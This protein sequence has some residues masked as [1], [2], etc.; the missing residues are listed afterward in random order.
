MEKMSDVV[1]TCEDLDTVCDVEQGTRDK[2]QPHGTNQCLCGGLE[3]C[4]QT[5]LSGRGGGF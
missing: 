4:W 1:V 3:S 5:S 2:K